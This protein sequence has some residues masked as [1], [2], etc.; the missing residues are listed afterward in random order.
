MQ[1]CKHEGNYNSLKR[2]FKF[3]HLFLISLQVEE[4]SDLEDDLRETLEC[5][6][7]ARSESS[8]AEDIHLLHSKEQYI[9]LIYASFQFLIDPSLACQDRDQKYDGCD[10]CAE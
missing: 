10:Y 4:Y 5:E 1:H 7:A 6:L 2:D 3:F 8:E 9:D